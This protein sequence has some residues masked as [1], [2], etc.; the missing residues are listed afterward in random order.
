VLGATNL[1]SLV[2]GAGSVLRQ[3]TATNF[4]LRAKGLAA[5]ILDAQPGSSAA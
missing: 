2:A 1:D 3:V 4:P 5:E